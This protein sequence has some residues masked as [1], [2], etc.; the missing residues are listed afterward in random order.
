MLSSPWHETKLSGQ[1]QTCLLYAQARIFHYVLERRLSGPRNNP[2]CTG[3]EKNPHWE[4]DP[5][6]AVF[7][8]E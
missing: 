1:L 6:H 3:K 7:L 8:L 5:G 4:P 2:A